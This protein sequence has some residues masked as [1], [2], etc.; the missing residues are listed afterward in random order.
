MLPWNWHLWE[1]AFFQLVYRSIAAGGNCFGMCLESIYARESRAPFVEPIYD[2]PDN[3]YS[4]D[5]PG[6]NPNPANANDTAV[7]DR[8]NVKM[9]Y[10]V[11][12]DFINWFIAMEVE[13]DTQD[14]VLAFKS[15]RDAYAGGNWPMIMLSPTSLSQDGHVVVPYQWL[16]SFGGAPP[17][18][19]SDQAINSQ[20]LSSQAWIVRVANPN[21][22]PNSKPNNDVD[23]EIRISPLANTWTFTGAGG[24]WSGSKGSD[25]R[26]FCAPYS[27]LDY[28][29]AMVGDFILGLLQGLMVVVFSGDGE[30]HQITDTPAA[31][32]SRQP[33][34]GPCRRARWP[35]ACRARSTATHGAVF[36]TWVSCRPITTRRTSR[37]GAAVRDL[38]HPAAPS[39]DG[40]V[41]APISRCCR[42]TRERADL[43]NGRR[44]LAV[45]LES[46]RAAH[47]G[48]RRLRDG[49][50]RTRRGS[51]QRRWQRFADGHAAYGCPG[52][53]TPIPTDRRRMARAR[54]PGEEGVHL[55]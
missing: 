24:N 37:G 28:E 13:N 32:T 39:G 8:V 38:L 18:E 14:A 16:V 48:R 20:P 49:C 30:T 10:Q 43:S 12:A 55:Q 29:P 40:L 36:P 22:T 42:C 7:I 51:S 54:S 53:R 21:A 4:H 23:C 34:A 5:A 45:S 47:V 2:S 19:A 44:G 46:E 27:L 6:V 41:A 50:R 33:C 15:S 11:G 26:I 3:T 25:G 1:R 31:R 17:I 35:P 9:G 52:G